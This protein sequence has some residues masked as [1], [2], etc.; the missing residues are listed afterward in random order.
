MVVKLGVSPSRSLLLTGSHRYHPGIVQ[1]AQGRSAE[2]A[3]SFHHNNQS[4][5]IYNGTR[6]FIAEHWQM[7]RHLPQELHTPRTWGYI[8]DRVYFRPLSRSLRKLR[9][10]ISDAVMSVA[11][12]LWGE[13]AFRWTCAATSSS[14]KQ[15]LECWANVVEQFVFQY[16]T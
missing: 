13:T 10:R 14:Y 15:R 11:V 5:T 16:V 4:T 12:R 3:V 7:A 1:Q 9:D 8:K 2:T 6:K